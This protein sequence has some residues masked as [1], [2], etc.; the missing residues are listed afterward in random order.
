MKASFEQNL[1]LIA[2]IRANQ[3]EAGFTEIIR[4]RQQYL[5]RPP[6]EL[7]IILE[8]SIYLHCIVHI[9]KEGDNDCLPKCSSARRR[10]SIM[11]EE[12]TGTLKVGPIQIGKP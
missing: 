10:R 6:W 9:C 1:K 7:I 8:P 12:G 5:T 4:Q 3:R 2:E 11:S